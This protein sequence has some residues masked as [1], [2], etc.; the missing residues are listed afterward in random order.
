MT[1]ESGGLEKRTGQALGAEEA[2]AGLRG[3]GP[4]TGEGLHRGPR[5][6]PFRQLWAGGM[7]VPARTGRRE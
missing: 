5:G 4:E 2:S 1:G 7:Q 6:G 3:D